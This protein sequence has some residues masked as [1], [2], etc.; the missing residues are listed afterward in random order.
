MQKATAFAERD[1][2]TPATEQGLI[3]KFNVSRVDGRDAPG[4]DRHGAR[5]FVLDLDHDPHAK[6]ALRAYAESCEDN[7]PQL[8]ADL[9]AQID[10]I[11]LGA[12]VTVPE[13]TLPSGL[14]V[15]AFQASQYL[16]SQSKDGA[17]WVEIN[18]HDARAACERADTRLITETQALAIAH[19]IAQQDINWTG[20][21]VGE[22]SIYQGL[23]K[24]SVSAAQG[25][26]LEPIDPDERRWHLLSN[27]ERIYDFAG[28]AFTW[29][30]DDVQGDEQGLTTRIAA[31]SIS[32][33][34]A[35]LPSLE[36]G[37]GWRP[38]DGANWSGFALLRG[39]YWDSRSRAGVFYLSNDWPDYERGSVGFRCTK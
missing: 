3:H 36:K 6:P 30:F 22:G 16:C 10:R 39:G 31:D 25:S 7:Y 29:V 35:P 12:F 15:P 37:M 5:Y 28:N 33:T 2:A 17:P 26:S 20:G 11:E 23:R 38:Q 9:L 21:K 34:T 24:G 32:L 4:G 27:G 18:Y 8:A 13:T 14:V 19:D 1:P